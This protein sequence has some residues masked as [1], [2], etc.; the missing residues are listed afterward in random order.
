MSMSPMNVN[1]VNY[2]CVGFSIKIFVNVGKIDHANIV[3]SIHFK[4]NNAQL[5]C[6]NY[7]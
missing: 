5:F 7:F 6:I 4:L 3:T 1:I 2:Y